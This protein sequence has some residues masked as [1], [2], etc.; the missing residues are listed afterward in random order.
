MEKIEPINLEDAFNSL[1]SSSSSGGG[2]EELL[3]V[4]S[5][6]TLQL[7]GKQIKCLLYLKIYISK[8]SD[9]LEKDTLNS[10]IEDYVLW[11]SYNN[12]QGFIMTALDN[13]SLRRFINENSLKVNIDKST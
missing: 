6:H 7:T 8:L 2:D 11:K 5:K 1:I 12:S 3:K 9:Q 13:I 10:F 4:A